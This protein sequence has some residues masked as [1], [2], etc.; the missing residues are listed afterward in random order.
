MSKPFLGSSMRQRMHLQIHPDQLMALAKHLATAGR[1]EIGG[2]LVGEHLAESR[3]R[4]A[5]LSFQRSKGTES[6]FVRRTEENESFL[7]SFFERTGDFRRFNYLGEWH[8]HPSFPAHASVTDH[9]AMQ[10]IVEDGPAAPLFAVLIVTRL[11]HDG[12]IE[13]SATA[14]R[15]GQP[16]SSVSVEVVPR[17][18]SDPTKPVRPWWKRIIQREAPAVRLEVA[19]AGPRNYRRKT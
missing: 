6:C 5:D 2:V 13:L 4:L 7:A 1:R 16:T 15:P 14:Y 19:E 12:G 11:A 9:R 18:P 17:S 3:F 10:A 8:S